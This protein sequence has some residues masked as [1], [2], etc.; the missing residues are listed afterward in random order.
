MQP[1][2]TVLNAL[3]DVGVPVQAIGKIRDIFAGSGITES[4]PTASN[5][6]GMQT[7]D[8]VWA[9]R[10]SKGLIFA[11]LVDFDMLFGHRRDVGGY[12][13]ALEQFD[14][15]LDGFIDRVQPDDLVI[16]TADHGNDPT[17]HGTDHT[18]EEVPLIVLHGGKAEALGTR[19]TFADVA[20]TLSEYFALERRWPVGEPFLLR[21]ESCY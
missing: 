14:S 10:S 11:N 1:P 20:A 7:I 5:E 4:A 12:R 19:T 18:R 21:A 3:C 2:R 16:I 6:E 8:R 9:D 17:H 13:R 15:W